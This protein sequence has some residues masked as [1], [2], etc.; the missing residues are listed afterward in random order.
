MNADI[1]LPKIVALSWERKVPVFTD[2]ADY[3]ARGLL[4][5]VTHDYAELGR[6]VADLIGSARQGI[7]YANGAVIL[8]TPACGRGAKG[9]PTRRS[10]IAA[11]R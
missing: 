8:Q 1:L 9:R 3:V 4:F 6:S 7:R 11:A 5:A 10:A 2:E